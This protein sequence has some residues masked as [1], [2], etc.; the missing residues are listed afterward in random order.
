[1]E[2]D[3][4]VKVKMN[5]RIKELA[6]QA[7]QYAEWTTPHGLEWFK[8]FHEKFAELLIKEC[9]QA[10]EVEVDTWKR[11]DPFQG[12]IKRL[13]SKAIKRHFGVEE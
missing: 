11:M 10:Y 3:S 2:Q 1:M 5:E 4:R 8:P 9:V 13:G 7:Q 6:D 12:S